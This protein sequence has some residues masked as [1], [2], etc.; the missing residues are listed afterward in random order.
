MDHSSSALDADGGAAVLGATSDA[1]PRKSKY[2]VLLAMLLVSAVSGGAWALMAAGSPGERLLRLGQAAALLILV[3]MW[4][5]FDS[6]ERGRNLPK[7]LAILIVLV[8]FIGLPVY[9]LR[10]RG[11]FG[12]L[13]TISKAVVFLGLFSLVQYFSSEAAYRA[14]LAVSE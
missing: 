9:L 3:L 11:V 1:N 7:W 13:V 12:G 10:S 5:H 14:Y 6:A 8:A 4:C 2:L